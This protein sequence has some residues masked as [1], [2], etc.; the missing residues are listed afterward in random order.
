MPQLFIINAWEAVMGPVNNRLLCAW[1]I[2]KCWQKNIKKLYCDKI[3]KITIYKTLRVLLQEPDKDKFL[4][5]LKNFLAMLEENPVLTDFK[6]Y[7][8]S[9]YA[10]NFKLW[11]FSYRIHLG[12]NTNMYLESMHKVIKHF[13]LEGK[14]IKRLD[15]TLNAIMRFTRDKIFDRLI[16]IMKKVP[17]SR[18]ERIRQS[19]DKSKNISNDMIKTVTEGSEWLVKSSEPRKLLEYAVQ[20]RNETF[21][22]NLECAQVCSICNIC[23]HVY[24]CKCLD[25][26]IRFNICKHIHACASRYKQS[27]SNEIE[28]H[29]EANQ[30]SHIED[31]VKLTKN[32]NLVTTTSSAKIAFNQKI[33]F[34][35][36]VKDKEFSNETPFS[37]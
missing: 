20:K 27:D 31:L 26:L 35:L 1:H 25:N 6:N 8:C 23:V 17:T 29:D 11:S 19:H 36:K 10:D 4:I 13:Y 32:Q 24:E 7:F 16:K 37:K 18:I 12:I 22:T 34:L 3:T 33:D 28:M 9:H 30:A 2:D 5:M 14:K 15:K 21:C